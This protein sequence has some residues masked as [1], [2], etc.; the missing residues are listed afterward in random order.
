LEDLKQKW[1][2]LQNWQS[3]I[4][5][6]VLPPAGALVEL[7]AIMATI[8][9][10]GWMLNVELAELEPSPFWLPVL[11][12]SLQ[13]GTVAGLLAAGVATAAY[14]FNGFPEQAIGE[15]LFSYLLR[16]WALPMLWV[17]VAL[18]LGQFRLRQIE[19]KQQLQRDLSQRSAEAKSLAA[20]S[21]ALEERCHRL[22]REMSSGA[23][24]SGARVLDA[25]AGL[26]SIDQDG[27][28]AAIESVF[29]GAQASLFSATPF[30]FTLAASSGWPEDAAWLR[31]FNSA[32][33]LAR[34]MLGDRRSVTV[35]KAGDEAL[36]ANQ[37]LAAQAVVGSDQGRVAGFI[38]IESADAAF[39]N[40]A[41][42]R[43]LG[44]L[45]RLVAPALCE[46]RIIV[47]NTVR[48]TED[49]GQAPVAP[50]TWRHAPWRVISSSDR[51]D[52]GPEDATPGTPRSGAS[53]PGTSRP[54]RPR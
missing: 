50:K 20:Y 28:A 29:P 9:L 41:L 46:P 48:E 30:G 24:G 45:A 39:I 42:V 23:A 21:S 54:G 26:S 47:S 37:G 27:F 2:R 8:F 12:L 3:A 43:R 33:P 10:S 17:G 4:W 32:H 13:Y 19:M 35:L 49:G 22:E 44:T 34:A 14:V 18:V 7:A 16:I 53:R 25:L 52:A 11:L 5:L 15:N 31:E 38:K 40:E 51:D 1:L 6:P 36:L